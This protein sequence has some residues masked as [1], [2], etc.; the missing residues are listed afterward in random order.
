MMPYY[1]RATNRGFFPPPPPQVI[2][3]CFSICLFVISHLTCG[4]PPPPGPTIPFP[5]TCVHILNRFSSL[6]IYSHIYAPISL[7]LLRSSLPPPLHPLRLYTKRN[8]FPHHPTILNFLPP[9]P[10]TTH[11][12][13]QFLSP[14]P[15]P[16]LL[17]SPEVEEE[18]TMNKKKRVTYPLSNIKK[19]GIFKQSEKKRG[20]MK[21]MPPPGWHRPSQKLRQEVRALQ[22]EREWEHASH[23]F[24]SLPFAATKAHTHARTPSLTPS[25]SHARSLFHMRSSK[26]LHSLFPPSHPQSHTRTAHCI[27]ESK[28]TGSNSTGHNSQLS[29]S[30]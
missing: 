20:A 24:P 18:A 21:L 12:L 25:L 15:H 23:H 8:T 30:L 2:L 7:S 19:G 14:P 22:R 16:P 17:A 9:T 3:S 29:S 4:P 5:F 10:P 13:S 1:V 6:H 27:L 26:P 28:M 11:C